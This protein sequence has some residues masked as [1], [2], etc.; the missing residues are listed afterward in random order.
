MSHR[1]FSKRHGGRPTYLKIAFRLSGLERRFV[2]VSS[3]VPGNEALSVPELPYN[4][5]C[6]EVAIAFVADVDRTFLPRS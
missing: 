4:I 6:A 5:L 3:V 1:A 2:E